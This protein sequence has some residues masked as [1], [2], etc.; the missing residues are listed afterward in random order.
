MRKLTLNFRQRA[1]RDRKAQYV[2]G[3]EN[4]LGEMQQKLSQLRDENSGL[5]QELCRAKMENRTLRETVNQL[6]FGHG[7]QAGGGSAGD[8]IG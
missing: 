7:Q 5:I 2:S 3:L 8:S 4:D 6:C 1:Y